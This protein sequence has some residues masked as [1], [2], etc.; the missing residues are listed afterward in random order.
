MPG[1]MNRGM[2]GGATVKHGRKTF[3][4]LFKEVFRGNGL[5]LAVV[6]MCIIISSMVTVFVSNMIETLIDQYITPLLTGQMMDFSALAM[7]M[8]RWAVIMLLG[9][10]SVYVYAR[11]MVT[12]A[13]DALMRIRNSMFEKL[14]HLPISYYDQTQHGA[15]M[16]L[17]TND[18]DTLQQGDVLLQQRAVGGD[19]DVQVV[20][21]LPQPQEEVVT[22]L[23]R[24]GFPAGQTHLSHAHAAHDLHQTDHLLIAQHLFVRDALVPGIAVTIQTAQVAAVRQ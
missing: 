22:A 21:A 3:L 14:E 1:P 18:A 11:I 8:V 15:T 9:V 13:Q 2:R 19:A 10:V 17:F 4:R 5:K 7:A 6:V 23:A 16:S 24:K 20:E 12:I